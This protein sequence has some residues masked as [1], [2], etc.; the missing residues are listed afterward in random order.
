[1]IYLLC[2]C[3]LRLRKYLL[4]TTK[5]IIESPKLLDLSDPLDSN[6]I[7]YAP[8]LLLLPSCLLMHTIKCKGS[9]SPKRLPEPAVSARTSFV[10]ENLGFQNVF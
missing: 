10:E 6:R 8:N 3:R 4:L 5:Y 7:T 2:C 1:M 9:L